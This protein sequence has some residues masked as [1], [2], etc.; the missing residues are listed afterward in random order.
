[1]LC[2]G[3]PMVFAFD[4]LTSAEEE[5]LR[6]LINSF[7]SSFDVCVKQVWDDSVTH[8][9]LNTVDYGIC[10]YWSAVYM[11]ALLSNCYIISTGWVEECLNLGY[12]VPEVY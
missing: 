6:R 2:K 11:H 4:N 10:E 1:M 9:I 3:R 7:A 12:L 5:M 8:L